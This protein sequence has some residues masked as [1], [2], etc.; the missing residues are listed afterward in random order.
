MPDM[1]LPFI[2]AHSDNAESSDF[3]V[4]DGYLEMSCMLKSKLQTHQDGQDRRPRQE[5]QSN[6]PDWFGC[7]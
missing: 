1:N 4:L 2:R 3:G 6:L 5:G 7:T